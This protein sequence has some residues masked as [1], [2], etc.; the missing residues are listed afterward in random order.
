MYQNNTI[1][2]QPKEDIQAQATVAKPSSQLDGL[3][4]K[5]LLAV[6]NEKELGLETAGLLE[7]VEGDMDF[8]D[9]GLTE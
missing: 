4:S 5:L 8:T 7:K 2:S 9:L 1:L 3:E 6:L